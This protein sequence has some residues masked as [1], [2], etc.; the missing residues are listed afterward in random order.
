M[1]LGIRL[2]AQLSEPSPKNEGLIARIDEWLRIKY[3]DMLPKTRL[4]VVESIPTLCCRLHPAAEDIELSFVGPS[5]L[6]ASANT[7]TVGPGYHAFVTSMLKELALEF[8]ARWEGSVEESEEYGDE[9]GFF[10]TGDVK[11][12]NAEMTAWLA[13]VANTFFD[14]SLDPEGSG[15]ALCLPMNPQF[16]VEQPAKTPLGPRDL[17]WLHRTAQ[18]GGSGTDFFAWW[19]P[20]INAEYYIG[21]ALTQMWVDVRWRPPISDSETEVLEDVLLVPSA[22]PTNSTQDFDTH[23]QSGGSCSHFSIE[24]GR[25]QSW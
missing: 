14:G 4:E 6:V 3:S 24:T 16:E 22:E 18:D 10:L 15:I 23:G 13:A 9:T 8:H 17:E 7:T 19:T 1:S 2:L 25:R 12:L 11:N 21:R 5:Q 20:G